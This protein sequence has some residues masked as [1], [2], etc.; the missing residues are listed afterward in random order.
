M[1]K[2]D[3]SKY[4]VKKPAYEVVPKTEV[5]GRIHAM[6]LMSNNLVPGVNTYIEA[7]GVLSMPSPNP[8]IG[9]HTHTYDEIV[10]HIG[11]DPKDPEELGAEIIFYMDGQ[12]LTIDKTSAI[13]VPR[14]VKHG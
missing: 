13:F 14:G 4:L 6:T 11:I 9:E 12:P 1:P 7:G 8:H 5:E 10:L 3:Y 2:K